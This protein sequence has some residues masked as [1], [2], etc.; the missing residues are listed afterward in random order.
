MTCGVND[1][2]KAFQW[3]LSEMWMVEKV[4]TYWTEWN[5]LCVC[6]CMCVCVKTRWD[7]WIQ[8]RRIHL[9][10][11]F[12]SRQLATAF[13]LYNIFLYT[14]WHLLTVFFL[15]L[16]FLQKKQRIRTKT[17]FQWAGKAWTLKMT[18]LFITACTLLAWL[19]PKLHECL[20]VGESG[21]ATSLQIHIPTVHMT[22]FWD[23]PV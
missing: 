15:S 4:I 20:K 16:F 2:T 6:M 3:K 5:N 10:I 11:F 8:L 7:L 14:S 21:T 13:N 18:H 12:F 1:I 9:S 19:N 17:D 23:L 22:A